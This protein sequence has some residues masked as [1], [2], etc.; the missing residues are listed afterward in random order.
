MRNPQY[1]RPTKFE[2]GGGRLR[3]SMDVSELGVGSRLVADLVASRY[4]EQLRNHARGRLLDLGCGKVP[5]YQAY[6]E[7]VSDVVCVDWADGDHIDRVCDLSDPLPFDSSTFETIVCSDVLEHLVDPALAWR[8]MSRVLS[9][10]GTVLMNV[11]FLYPIHAHPHDYFRYT[12]FAL[13]RFA[14]MNSLEVLVLE[15]VGGLLEVIADLAGKAITKVPA[16][17]PAM[18]ALQ[19][20]MAIAWARS[21]WGRRIAAATARNYPLGYFMVVRKG[22]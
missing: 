10:G 7:L 4:Q 19:Q 5:L 14:R 12:G 6:R 1:W 20:A 11:P 2:F 9:P 17:G 22:R 16:M 18:A 13:D 3:S 21:G 15:P 8:E